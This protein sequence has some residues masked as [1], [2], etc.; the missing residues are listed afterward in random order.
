[1][2]RAR[3]AKKGSRKQYQF[4]EC[5]KKMNELRLACRQMHNPEES[6]L[7]EPIAIDLAHSP[8]GYTPLY[9]ERMLPIL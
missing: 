7:D 9:P 2:I 8:D 1:L 3:L 4:R 5:T 6:I